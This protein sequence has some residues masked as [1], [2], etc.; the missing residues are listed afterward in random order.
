MSQRGNASN[1]VREALNARYGNRTLSSVLCVLTD[2]SR[3]AAQRS[4]AARIRRVGAFPSN[5]GVPESTVL[6]SFS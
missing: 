5:H 6:R 2:K 3:A 1:E 4:H